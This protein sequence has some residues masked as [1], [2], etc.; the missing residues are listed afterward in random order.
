[1]FIV[2]I[3]INELI[4]PCMPFVFPTPPSNRSVRASQ[5]NEE[6]GLF[7]NEIF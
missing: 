2:I 1:M 4:F 7:V 5:W 6:V 3:I